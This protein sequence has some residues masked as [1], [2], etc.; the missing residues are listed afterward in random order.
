MVLPSSMKI[1]HVKDLVMPIKSPTKDIEDDLHKLER[2]IRM[3]K[4]ECEQFFGGGKKRPPDDT[5]WRI[6]QTVKR[7]SDRAGHLNYGQRFLYGNLVQAYVKMRDV[8]HKRLKKREEGAQN[9]HFGEAARKL[10]AEREAAR[11]AQ[12]IP[13]VAVVCRNPEREPRKVEQIYTAFR[14]AIERSGESASQITREQFE[15]FLRQKTEELRKTKGTEEV[16]FVVSVEGGKARL[17]A[18]VRS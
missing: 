17:K 13:A 1:D 4:I 7:Y 14:E 6:E 11:K 10:Q 2:D 9:R 12:P 16:E 15:Q 18:R 5:E 8:F 3:Y